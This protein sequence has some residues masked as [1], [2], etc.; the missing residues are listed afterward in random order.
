MKPSYNLSLVTLL[1]R[2]QLFTYK[3]IQAKLNCTRQICIFAFNFLS[4]KTNPLYQVLNWHFLYARASLRLNSPKTQKQSNLKIFSLWV[5]N[6][7]EGCFFMATAK[8]RFLGR[9]VNQKVPRQE[10]DTMP[11]KWT[12]LDCSV[13]WLNQNL[14]L[15]SLAAAFTLL[16]YHG[17]FKQFLYQNRWLISS[18]INSCPQL[19]N[20]LATGQKHKSWKL[21]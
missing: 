6:S 3:H 17:L 8:K 16:D 15:I 9:L 19:S 4:L 10:W 20:S 21:T 13:D 14:I 18:S 12:N 2:N 7:V 1:A 11:W 5:H